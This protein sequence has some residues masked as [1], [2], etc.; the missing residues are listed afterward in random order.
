MRVCKRKAILQSCCIDF[1]SFSVFNKI[2]QD[3]I[4]FIRKSAVRI[5]LFPMFSITYHIIQMSEHIKIRYSPDIGYCLPKC[6]PVGLF[7]R[8]PLKELRII[9]ILP[10]NHMHGSDH[11]IIRICRGKCFCFLRK[12]WLKSKLHTDPD[13][14]L[15]FILFLQ[16]SKLFKIGFRIKHKFN[17][18]TKIINIFMIRKTD[19]FQSFIDCCK[20]HIFRFC[21]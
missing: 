20:N 14:Q 7:I 18:I 17:I 3:F 6:H 16:C 21:L 19:C 2:P 11:K 5:F 12:V 15:L 10:T 8:N 13:I 4:Y 9:R 1:Q